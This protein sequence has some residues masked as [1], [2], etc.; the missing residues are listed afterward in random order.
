MA[1]ELKIVISAEDRAS[2]VLNKVGKAIQAEAAELHGLNVIAG[3]AARG[4][5]VMMGTAAGIAASLGMA[6]REAM[7]YEEAMRNVNSLLR[8]S[9]GDFQNL[10]RSVLELARDPMV[11]DMPATLAKGLYQIVSAGYQGRLA[12]DVLR[13][14]SKG[15]AAGLSDTFTAADALTTIMNAYNDRTAPA[16]QR[17]MDLMFKTVEKGKTTFGELA[18]SV[19]LVAGSAAQA[20][21]SFEEVSAALAIMTQKGIDTDLAVTSLNRLILRFLQPTKEMQRMLQQMGYQSGLAAL[22]QL[23]LAGAMK[24]LGDMVGWDADQM[25][26]FLGETRAIRAAMA[27]AEDDGRG[28]IAMLQEMQNASGAT[29]AALEQ[30]A[31]STAFQWKKLKQELKT[32]AIEVGGAVLP[33]FRQGIAV[34]RQYVERF[35]QLPEA[36]QQAIVKGAMT[37]AVVAGLTGALLLGGAAAMRLYTSVVAAV[38][39]M[40]AL[41]AAMIAAQGAEGAGGLVGTLG[42]IVRYARQLAGISPKQA[43]LQEILATKKHL[44]EIIAGLRGFGATVAS[45]PGRLAALGPAIV[46][47]LLNPLTWVAAAAAVATYSVYRTIRA[48]QEMRKAQEEAK[49]KEQEARHAEARAQAKGYITYAMVARE[50]GLEEKWR[51][52]RL[53]EEEQAQLRE[54]YLRRVRERRRELGEAGI[55]RRQATVTAEAQARLAAPEMPAV[56]GMPVA[57][58]QMPQ[59]RGGVMQRGETNIVNVNLRAQYSNRD[60]LSGMVDD[61]IKAYLPA[62]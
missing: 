56:P 49:R 37:V 54:L 8:A 4:G 61:V 52:G 43:W 13:V 11:T 32:T 24:L 18:S 60:Q 3:I 31:R 35:R 45:L 2:A 42:G 26:Q 55:A 17:Y 16:A 33:V 39:A 19:G 27:L 50:L 34:V 40:S 29:Q 62:Y 9:E 20:G 41:R 44:P 14:A 53:S 10:Y 59:V 36:Q 22:Q 25:A 6:G 28:Y 12:L 51:A 38:K 1:E 23:G 15:A 57:M 47:F 21:V 5:A 30:Q 7:G 58:V 48:Y 46:N